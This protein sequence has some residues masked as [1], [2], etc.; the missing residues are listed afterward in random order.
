MLTAA[1][2]DAV[3]G[4]EKEKF[5][6]FNGE[7]LKR[8]GV[9]LRLI[10]IVVCFVALFLS[11]SLPM[12]AIDYASYSSSTTFSPE[13][14]A[15]FPEELIG[16]WNALFGGDYFSYYLKSKYGPELLYTTKASF[17]GIAFGI[18]VFTIFIAI[19]AFFVTFSKRME[20]YSK[21][22]TLGYFVGGLG[23]LC[24]PIWFMVANSFGNTSAVATTDLTHYFLYDSLYVHCGYGAVVACFVY[25]LAAILFGVG[26]SREMAGGDNREGENG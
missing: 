2:N 16:G 20:K 6:V 17:N 26:T 19:L 22:V 4:E 21:I 9:I 24:S 7:T 5:L 14:A 15:R 23:M 1:V 25:I 12:V 13:R 18:L 8:P 11:A 10:S 3:A